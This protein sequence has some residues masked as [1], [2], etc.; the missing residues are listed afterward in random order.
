MKEFLVEVSWESKVDGITDNDTYRLLAGDS[1]EAKRNA[2]ALCKTQVIQGKYFQVE[3][4]FARC[5]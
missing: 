4:V 1:A 5:D 3:S 2:L